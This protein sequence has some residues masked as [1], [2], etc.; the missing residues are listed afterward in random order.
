MSLVFRLLESKLDLIVDFKLL[1][2]AL[3]TIFGNKFDDIKH[4]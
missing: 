3:K 1:E 2:D 4:F